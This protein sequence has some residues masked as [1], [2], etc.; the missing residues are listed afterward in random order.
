MKVITKRQPFGRIVKSKTYE[1]DGR[2]YT[3]HATKGWRSERI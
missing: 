3:Y 1:K 2:R